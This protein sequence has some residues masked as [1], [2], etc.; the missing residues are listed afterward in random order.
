MKLNLDT[1][2]YVK[3]EADKADKLTKYSKNIENKVKYDTV[4]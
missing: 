4:S 1:E 2:M 3:S